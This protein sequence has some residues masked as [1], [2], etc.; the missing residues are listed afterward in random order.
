[1]DLRYFF[2]NFQVIFCKIYSKIA[3]L[4]KYNI[5]TKLFY[6]RNTI[7]LQSCF[8]IKIQY[9][10]KIILLSKYN[11]VTKLFYYQNTILLQSCFATKIQHKNL[12]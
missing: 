1:M 11:I 3:L 9:C 5:V 8:T 4:L 10:Q 2:G 12:R 7:L 6:Y